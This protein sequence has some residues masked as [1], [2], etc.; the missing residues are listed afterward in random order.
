MSDQQRI[1]FIDNES[2]LDEVEH[3][4]DLSADPQILRFKVVGTPAP[5]GSKKAFYNPKIKRA[6]VV[7]DSKKT[8]P[9][10]IAVSE[11]AIEALEDRPPIEGPVMVSIVFYLARPQSHY[12]TGRNAGQ[13]KPSAP[14]RPA[15][16]PDIDKLCRSTLDALGDARVFTQDS[17]IVDLV[18][19]KR[20]ADDQ[21]R[22]GAW[23]AVGP[24]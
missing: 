10:R 14:S 15:V 23:I 20:F 9:W 24:V 2:S 1:V 18:V 5:Q 22:P 6:V 8:R 12:G 3:R 19:A 17:Q 13:V 4:L 7:D 16:R 11:A 21:V